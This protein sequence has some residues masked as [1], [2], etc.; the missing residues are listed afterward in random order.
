MEH[1]I[2]LPLLLFKG[3]TYMATEIIMPKAG[4]A[5]EEGT[6]VKWF[7]KEGD[8][9][10]SGEP[11]LEILTDKVNMEVEATESGTLLKIL[12]E[13]GE[14]L[15]VITTIG[16]IGKEGEEIPQ[17]ETPKKKEKTEKNTEKIA[18]TEVKKPQKTAEEAGYDVVVLGAGP[19]GYVAA[20]RAAQLG[21][22]VALIEEEAIGG[23]CLNWGCIPTKTLVKNAEILHLIE[24][25]S[26]RGIK[27][28]KPEIDIKQMMQTKDKVVKQMV[29]GIEVILKSNNIDIIKGRGNV[30]GDH[31]I[32]IISGKDQGKEISYKKLII[33]TG[34]KAFIPPIPGLKEEG[35]LTNK[36]ILS[37]EEIPKHLIVIGGGVIGAEFATI[38]KALGSEVTIVEMAPKLVPNMDGDISNML[39]ESLQMK[40]INVLVDSKVEEV[41]KQGAQYKVRVA[42]KEEKEIT[43]DKILVSVGRQP[44]LEAIKDSG[45]KTEKKGIIVNE[46]L[47]TNKEDI[48]A[49]GDVTGEILL[50]HVA[51]TQG[52]IAVENALGKTREMD[53]RFVPSGIYTIPEIGSVGLTEEQAKA[54]YENI[55]VG[56]FPLTASGKALAM[57]ETDGLVKVITET[58]YGEI[59]G[60]HIFGAN[61]TEII[62]EATAIMQLE[63]TIEELLRII[64]AHPTMAESIMEAGHMAVGEPIHLPKK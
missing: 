2:Y 15:P 56:K 55:S 7:K 27:I 5:M 3:G 6:I 32:S 39:K 20:I 45:V 16:Y 62:A 36:E 18:M 31:S 26:G 19:G 64:H 14:V 44:N 24:K 51:S 47:E 25:A 17:V 61:A 12:A 8:P 22:K 54:K 9:V 49:I 29:G 28:G 35:I 33:A 42:G 37:L 52:I 53:Y 23:T 43:G 34:S 10:E 4:M 57:D 13:E 38:F 40:G 59:L 1:S 41:K 48:Y 46:K 50:A 21:A 11:L 30:Q 58:K 60:V 63:G